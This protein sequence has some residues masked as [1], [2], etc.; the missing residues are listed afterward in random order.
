MRAT[1][2]RPSPSVSIPKQW[3]FVIS[4]LALFSA[5]SHGQLSPGPATQKHLEITWSDRGINNYTVGLSAGGVLPSQPGT[6]F[7]LLPMPGDVMVP[8]NQAGWGGF[9]TSMEGFFKAKLQSAHDGGAS[10]VEFLTQQDINA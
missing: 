8:K 6:I 3:H 5:I 10:R 2:P 4:L 7:V 9:E 1:H